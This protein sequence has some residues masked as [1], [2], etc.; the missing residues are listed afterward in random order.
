MLAPRAGGETTRIAN[1]AMARLVEVRRWR[2]IRT[3]SRLWD[4][5]LSNEQARLRRYG[6]GV[7]VVLLELGGFADFATWVGREAAMQV[8]SRLSRLIV[9][10]VRSSDHIARIT[11][12]R[13]AILLFETDEVRTLNFINRILAAC[14]PEL[15]AR[16]PLRIGIG[17]ASP[18][19]GQQLADA[20]AL[21][22]ERL[23]S[24]FFGL[25]A[26]GPA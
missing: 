11:S 24:D 16:R 2:S 12:E 3:G 21:A 1:V 25:R 6:R 15:R 22:E 5:I 20:V 9:G 4:R 19:K 18:A 17:W 8:F 10:E 26:D 14:E 7:T 23:N 13:F